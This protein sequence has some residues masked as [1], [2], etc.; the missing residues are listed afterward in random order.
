MSAFRHGLTMSGR[1]RKADFQNNYCASR[2]ERHFQEKKAPD[3]A[4]ALSLLEI[5]D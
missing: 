4:G 1:A 5:I 2:R 3:D